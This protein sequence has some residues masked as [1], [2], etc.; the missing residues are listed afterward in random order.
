MPKRKEETGFVPVTL[1]HP[2]R[3]GETRR[4]GSPA[5]LVNLKA[6]GWRPR[7][8]VALSTRN[9]IKNSDK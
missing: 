3:K 6:D 7:R 9:T 1:F 4:A 2:A 8:P 5:Q